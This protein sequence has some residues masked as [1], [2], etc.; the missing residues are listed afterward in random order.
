MLRCAHK[1]CGYECGWTHKGGCDNERLEPEEGEFYEIK[2]EFKTVEARRFHGDKN[3]MKLLGCPKC[4]R[5]F[6][7]EG[8]IYL[9]G[10]VN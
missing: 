9:D 8:D 4:H 6:M 5:L 3:E 10:K 1:D 2:A 7:S